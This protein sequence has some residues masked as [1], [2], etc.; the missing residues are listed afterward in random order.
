MAK[1]QKQLAAIQGWIAAT[2][3]ALQSGDCLP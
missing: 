2:A 1:M 3:T